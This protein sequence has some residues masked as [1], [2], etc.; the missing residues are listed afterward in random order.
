MKIVCFLY[1]HLKFGDFK[2]FFPMVPFQVIIKKNGVFQLKS[3]FFLK[4]NCFFFFWKII[5]RFIKCV[6][7]Q[8]DTQNVSHQVSFDEIWALLASFKSLC[9]CV[10]KFEKKKF[11]PRKILKFPRK[12]IFLN[13]L[14]KIFLFENNSN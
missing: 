14:K 3:S 12:T 1:V 9:G 13:F 6:V 10:K 8:I 7:S 11:F 2:Q 5:F 4:K